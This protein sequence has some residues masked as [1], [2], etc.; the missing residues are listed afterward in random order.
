MVAAGRIYEIKS[1]APKHTETEFAGENEV[2][3]F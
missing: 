3:M 1:L 2:G